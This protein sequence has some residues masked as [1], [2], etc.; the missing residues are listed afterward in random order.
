MSYPIIGV[1]IA[2]CLVALPSG[3][4]P[5]PDHSS[6]ASVRLAQ[7]TPNCRGVMRDAI[8]VPV[9]CV[10]GTAAGCVATVTECKSRGG[11]PNSSGAK[12]CD[13][14][15]SGGGVPATH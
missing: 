5:L 11:T 9:C 3:A 2:L 8:K 7:Q 12:G 10:R 6:S 15:A 1:S 4:Q 13:V 14:P